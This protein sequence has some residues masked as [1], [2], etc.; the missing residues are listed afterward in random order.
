MC[1]MPFITINVCILRVTYNVWHAMCEHAIYDMLCTVTRN[2]RMYT[3]V[4]SSSLQI[5]IAFWNQLVEICAHANITK[6]S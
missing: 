3:R 6:F 4:L 2:D 1:D 5:K